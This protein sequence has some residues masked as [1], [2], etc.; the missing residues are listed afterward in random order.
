MKSILFCVSLLLFLPAHAQIKDA[1]TNERIGLLDAGTLKLTTGKCTDCASSPQS[2]WFFQDDDIAAPTSTALVAGV[3]S[4]LDRRADVK[5]W[6]Q[7][8]DA[9]RLAY[10]TVTWIG[11]PQILEGATIAADGKQVSMDGQRYDFTMVPKIQTNLSYANAATTAYLHQ[12]PLRMRGALQDKA[13]KPTFVAR[14]TWPTDY[15]IDMQRLS[16]QPLTQRAD[17]KRYVQDP[18]TAR[19]GAVTTRL[20]WERTPGAGRNAAGKPVM[21]IMLNGAQGDDDESLAGHFGITTGYFGPRGEW[22]DWAMNNIYSLDSYSEKGIIAATLPMDNYLTDLNSGQQYYRPSYMLVAVLKNARTAVAFQGGIQRTLNHFYR[23]DFVY[24]QSSGN[25]AGVSIDVLRDLGWH[26]PQE[27]PTSRIKAV[28]A[29]AYVAA[30]EQSL[31]SGRGIYDN[32]NE[33]QTRLF[34][35]RA[36]DAAGWDL[37]E[38]V[39]GAPSSARVLS[40]YEQQLKEDVEA[41]MLVKIAQIPSSRVW[42]SAPVYSFDEYMQRTPSKR[43]DWKI[44]PVAPRPF[45]VALR[46]SGAPLPSAPSPVPLPV[47]G[48]GAAGI[49]GASA[50]WRRRKKAASVTL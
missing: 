48:I 9:A 15:A 5:A 26:I 30:T 32:L 33:E 10:P 46:D 4:K 42:G 35:A 28:A 13:G 2:L 18:A 47:M 39:N 1:L 40:P 25:C 43:A 34:P 11:A 3:S 19:E 12:R 14:T 50:W 45:P 44:V 49:I 6:A 31:K 8:S 20:I 29:Y 16:L 22:A 21:G 27:G 23:H 38:L 37:L 36:F 41:I 7:S 24:G 17:L